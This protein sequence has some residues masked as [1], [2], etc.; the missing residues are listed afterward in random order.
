[1][2]VVRLNSTGSSPTYLPEELVDIKFTSKIWTERYKANG[3]FEFRT[4]KIKEGRALLP[5]RSLAAVLQRQEV[6]MV[7]THNIV[8]GDAG[9]ELVIKGR[10]LTA[11]PEHRTI[12]GAYQKKF[13][14]PK[15][16]TYAQAAEVLLWN[17]LVNTTDNDV[18][19]LDPFTKPTL[20]AIPNVVVTDNVN[21]TGNSKN[22]WLEPGPVNTPLEQFLAAGKLGI[23]MIRP[24]STG[25][26]V[27]IDRTGADRGTYSKAASGTI[28]KLRFD[29][30]DG[31]DRTLSQTA[32][33]P[34]IFRYISDDVENPE[35]LFDTTIYKTL[36]DVVGEGAK[37]QVARKAADKSLTGLERRVMF[38]DAGAPEEHES[39]SEFADDVVDAGQE[40]LADNDKTNMFSGDVSVKSDYRYG[41]DYFL[42]DKITFQGNY[43]VNQDMF[44][45]EFVYTH[46]KEGERGFPGFTLPEEMDDSGTV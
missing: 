8:K 23:R 11:F 35:Y 14:M 26:V 18:V 21:S 44:V 13:K 7:D 3:D 43:G 16:Y 5:E 42:G 31:L 25:R 36:A 2:D 28:T 45:T 4:P 19:H 34:V 32:R 29:I 9:P 38:V 39:K 37:K 33:L 17:F 6:M 1:M 24:D 12:Q 22:R 41:V 15:K 10:S 40:A 27:T 30:Y 46:D 20:D